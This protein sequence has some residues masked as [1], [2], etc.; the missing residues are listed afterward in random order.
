VREIATAVPDG[1][2]VTAGGRSVYF[3]MRKWALENPDLVKAF[4]TAWDRTVR[5]LSSD[6]G[7]HLDEAAGIAARELRIP[8]AVALYDLKD[9]SRISWGW[10]V[11]DYKDAVAAIKKFQDYQIA[12]KDPFYTK[13]HLND[14]EIEAFVD[15]R[16]FAGGDYFVDVSEK[17]QGTATGELGAKVL[18]TVQLA[19]SNYSH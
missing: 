14:Q 15:K 12:V 6:N 16:F 19:C 8:K 2:Y 9:E 11:T 1:V 3:A 13:H 4:L 7:K 5:W 10:G 17:Q 18:P